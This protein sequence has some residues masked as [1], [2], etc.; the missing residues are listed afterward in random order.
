MDQFESSDDPRVKTDPMRRAA[1]P[2]AGESA[3]ITDGSGGP[4]GGDG[5]GSVL[6]EIKVR[7]HRQLLERLNLSNIDEIEKILRSGMTD[8]D[9]F[10]RIFRE[11]LRKAGRL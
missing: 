9:F 6:Q 2:E 11:G 8:N 1:A 5:S 7:V 10:Y 4:L 3:W